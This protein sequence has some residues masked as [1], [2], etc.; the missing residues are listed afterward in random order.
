MPASQTIRYS[1][2]LKVMGLAAHQVGIMARQFYGK[3]TNIEKEFGVQIRDGAMD[4][5]SFATIRTL[6][7]CV[8][9]LKGTSG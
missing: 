8:E 5:S 3:V 4:R 1:D 6:A 2:F 9:G 7:D